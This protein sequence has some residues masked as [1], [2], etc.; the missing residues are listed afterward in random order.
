MPAFCVFIFTDSGGCVQPVFFCFFFLPEFWLQLMH[1]EMLSAVR[2]PSMSLGFI[3]SA[4]RYLFPFFLLPF[5][6]LALHEKHER[7][8]RVPSLRDDSIR[9]NP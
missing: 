7:V 2:C 1:Q 5:L 9:F 8:V 6:V 3:T 4:E